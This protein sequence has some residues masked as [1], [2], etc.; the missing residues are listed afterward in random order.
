MATFSSLQIRC[1]S[2]LSLSL[3]PAL[4]T[5]ELIAAGRFLMAETDASLFRS[6]RS[7]AQTVEVGTRTAAAL[8]DQATQLER[9]LDDADAMR[10][11][12]RRGRRVIVDV[13]RGAATDR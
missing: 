5:P 13:A 10:G 2:F 4:S 3:L 11:A 9:I 7:I 12:A 1:P 8:A 6:A